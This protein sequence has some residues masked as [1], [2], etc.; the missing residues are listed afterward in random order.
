MFNGWRMHISLWHDFVERFPMVLHS[1]YRKNKNSINFHRLSAFSF[2]FVVFL[3]IFNLY[4]NRIIKPSSVRWIFNLQILSFAIS[5]V[6]ENSH[7]PSLYCLSSCAS[8][9]CFDIQQII[10]VLCDGKSIWEV[11]AV[12]SICWLKLAIGLLVVWMGWCI[13]FKVFVRKEL[14]ENLNTSFSS[15][16]LQFVTSECH[17]DFLQNLIFRY[18]SL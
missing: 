11:S 4:V 18:F 10:N 13:C 3:W 17:H 14:V 1:N 5:R 2:T 7:S 8:T 9:N 12:S 16:H 15:N 6:Q